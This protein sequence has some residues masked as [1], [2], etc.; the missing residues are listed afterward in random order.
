MC[1]RL[2]IQRLRL[3]GRLGSR[4]NNTSWMAVVIP[5]DRPKSV[6]KSIMKHV[7]RIEQYSIIKQPHGTSKSLLQHVLALSYGE[8]GFMKPS[9]MKLVSP[10]DSPVRTPIRDIHG[11][12]SEPFKFLVP[13]LLFFRVNIL[14]YSY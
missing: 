12:A 2:K 9:S 14:R 8:T 13:A 7:A 11:Y 6:L 4:F 1:V 10:C 3:V 5:T